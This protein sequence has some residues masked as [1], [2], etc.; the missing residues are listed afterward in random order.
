MGDTELT[1]LT[2]K[3]VDGVV[4]ELTAEEIKELEAMHAQIAQSAPPEPAPEKSDA[5]H[6]A[7]RK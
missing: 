7:K 6:R 5:S 2:H 4:V 3:L 1:K